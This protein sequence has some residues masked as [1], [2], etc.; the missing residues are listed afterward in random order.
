MLRNF[1]KK[2]YKKGPKKMKY[3]TSA[4]FYQAC[5]E[6]AKRCQ[7]F[8]IFGGKNLLGKTTDILAMGWTHRRDVGNSILDGHWN[9]THWLRLTNWEQISNLTKKN[10][11]L[12]KSQLSAEFLLVNRWAE[13]RKNIFS[14]FCDNF[15][16]WSVTAMENFAAKFKVT[17][18]IQMLCSKWLLIAGYN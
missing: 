11:N 13:L 14:R 17:P 9:P 1:N 5:T 15:R 7:P 16:G 3:F 18:K 2:V 4:H 10:K 12:L 6:T 8:W